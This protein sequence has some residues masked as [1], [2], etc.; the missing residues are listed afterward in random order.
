M[1]ESNSIECSSIEF[2]EHNSIDTSNLN[3]QQFRLNKISEYEDYF[4]TEIKERELM[5]K[6]LSK[7]ISFF[8]CFDRSLTVLLATSGR[9]SIASFT[10]V[11]GTPVGIASASFSLVF[12]LCTG[13][14]KKILK[15]TRNKKKK[16]N[17]I[18]MLA[19]SKLNSIESKISEALIK[20]QISHEDFMTIIDEERNYRE[21][22]ESIRLMKGQE[23]KNVYV[24]YKY[25]TMVSYCLKCKKN[26]ERIDPK[27]SETSNG[28]TMILSKC[29]ICGSKISKFI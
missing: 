28:K 7:Y 14:V 13:L 3:N 10:T 9:V 18:V 25:K 24:D 16:H 1:G 21:L 20:N 11:I 5:S 27:V 19:R 22:K 15:A 29:A 12:S 2:I 6:K 17:I 4:I 8:D 23:D 26:T